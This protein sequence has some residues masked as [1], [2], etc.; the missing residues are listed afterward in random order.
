M[1]L[2]KDMCPNCKERNGFQDVNRIVM[3]LLKNTEFKCQKCDGIFKYANVDKHYAED[4]EACKLKPRCVLCPQST[5]LFES[6][7]HIILHWR[8]ECQG[9]QVRCSQ[10]EL[11]FARGYFPQHEC[12]KALKEVNKKNLVKI[13]M[14][15]HRLK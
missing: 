11:T 10:C 13:E 15:E 6:K 4:C 7:E 12:M 5:P 8:E 3:T 14:L 2:N 1:I 9:I